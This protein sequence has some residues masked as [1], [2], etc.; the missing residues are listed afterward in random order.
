MLKLIRLIIAMPIHAKTLI[1]STIIIN[2]RR[3]CAARV[4]VVG[5]VCVCVCLSVCLSVTQHLAYG[6]FIIGSISVDSTFIVLELTAVSLFIDTVARITKT[7]VAYICIHTHFILT[8][9]VIPTLQCYKET[10]NIRFIGDP[11]NSTY[12]IIVETRSFPSNTSTIMR[13]HYYL[14]RQRVTHD[15]ASIDNIVLLK[16]L[17][18]STIFRLM[19]PYVRTSA[20]MK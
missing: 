19:H 13:N 1:C 20:F 7:L 4:T 6:M 16:R 10:R 2:P 14:F 3:A 9:C 12:N 18:V 8:T 17:L 11:A 15:C 5:S